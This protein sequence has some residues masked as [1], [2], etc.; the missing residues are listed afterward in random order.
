MSNQKLTRVIRALIAAA[1]CF[2]K[3]VKVDSRSEMRL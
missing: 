3:L 2:V 1:D